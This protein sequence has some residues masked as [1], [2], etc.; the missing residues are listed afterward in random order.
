[1]A[2]NPFYFAEEGSSFHAMFELFKLEKYPQ[3]F[4]SAANVPMPPEER[5]ALQEAEFAEYRAWRQENP[6]ARRLSK[7]AK[8]EGREAGF[9]HHSWNDET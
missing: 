5:K 8:K 3:G 7:V 1:M 6:I 4:P 9:T 2:F